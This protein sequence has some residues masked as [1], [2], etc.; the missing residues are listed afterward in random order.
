MK[1]ICAT[2]FSEPSMEATRVAARLARRFGDDLLLVHAWTSPFLLYREI[3]TDPL[4]V[5]EKLIGKATAD[6][7]AAV[8]TLRSEGVSVGTR[9][10]RSGDPAEAIAALGKE[11]DARLIVVGARS[12]RTAPRLFIGSAAERTMLLADRPVLV[13]HPGSTGLEEWANRERPLRLVVGLDRSPASRTAVDWVR[14]LRALG[15]CDVVFVHAFW[16]TAEYGRLGLHGPIDLASSEAETRRV[17]ARELRPLFEELPGTGT[18]ELRLLPVWGSAAEPILDVAKATDADLLV[19]GTNQRGALARLWAGTTVQP[20]VRLAQLPVLCVPA[21]QAQ[22]AAAAPRPQLRNILVATDFSELG[23]RAVA[24]AYELARGGGTVALCHVR[25]RVL[26]VPGPAHVD[27]HDA[28]TD[29][30]RRELEDRLR[31]LIPTEAVGVP[32]TL[33]LVDGGQAATVIVQEANRQ[34]VDAI[35]VGSHGRSG[36]GRALMGSVAETVA[37][38]A[39]RP[40]LIVRPGT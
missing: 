13:V 3:I 25:E 23:N 37:R 36:L 19:M 11:I 18:V 14:A 28:L 9:V 1:I 2:D 27:E 29:G 31:A 10:L 24:Y 22:E 17:L 6:L 5:E 21:S 15:P 7:E 35:C 30:Q 34:G 33:T 4:Q 12:G 39:Q 26:P 16:A 38:H 40:V 32:T 8:R 20:T